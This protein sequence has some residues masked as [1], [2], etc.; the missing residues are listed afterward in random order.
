MGTLLAPDSGVPNLSS[1]VELAGSKSTTD[2]GI[3]LTNHPNRK[4]LGPELD[5]DPYRIHRIATHTVTDFEATMTSHRS[6]RPS[7]GH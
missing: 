2:G 1:H 5:Q 4:S 3:L 6:T 7:H